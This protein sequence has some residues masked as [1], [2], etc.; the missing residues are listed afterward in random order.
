VVSRKFRTFIATH[1]AHCHNLCPLT[2]LI[3]LTVETQ[4][5]QIVRAFLN[6]VRGYVVKTKAPDDLAPTRSRKFPAAGRS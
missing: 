1:V 5:H 6:G 3:V 2:H 4:E